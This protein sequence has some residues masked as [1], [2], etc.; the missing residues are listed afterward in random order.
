M[1]NFEIC[2]FKARLGGEM[3]LTDVIMHEGYF[4]PRLSLN[5]IIGNSLHQ[6]KANKLSGIY[7][8]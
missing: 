7:I 4:L 8:Q 5:L 6:D 3:C 1:I 2:I